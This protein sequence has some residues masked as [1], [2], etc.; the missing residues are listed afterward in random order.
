MNLLS[1]IPYKQVNVLFPSVQNLTN[2]TY[3][4]LF[5]V[6]GKTASCLSDKM[7]E[8]FRYFPSTLMEKR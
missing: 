6:F 7:V 4:L 8:P 1:C 5:T 2:R 3:R